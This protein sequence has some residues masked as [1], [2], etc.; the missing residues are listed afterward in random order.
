MPVNVVEYDP[1]WQH[2]FSA[3]RDALTD[4]LHS[5]LAEPVEHVG[6]TAVPGLASKPIVDIVAPVASLV[7]AELAVPLLEDAGWLLWPADP[8]RSWRLWFLRPQPDARTHH[9]YLIQHNDPHL[10]ELCAFRDLLRADDGLRTE[11]E[12]LKRNL[13]NEFRDDREA[14]TD[15][16]AHF[17]ETT[18]RDNGLE[19]RPRSQ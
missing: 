19:P 1:R 7:E 10:R 12:A 16:K 11:Y 13:A 6:S 5:W 2:S 18:L 3:Q 8:N 14:Y 15:A 9:L 4:L 17:I